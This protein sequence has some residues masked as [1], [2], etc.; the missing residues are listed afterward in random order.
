[1]AFHKMYSGEYN[2]IRVVGLEDGKSSIVD[3]VIE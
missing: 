1:M 3:I 2:R